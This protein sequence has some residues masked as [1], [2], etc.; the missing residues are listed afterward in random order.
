MK[1]NVIGILFELFLFLF[2]ACVFKLSEIL[3][4]RV[5]LSK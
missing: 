5:C 4:Y 1:L 2:F 3:N